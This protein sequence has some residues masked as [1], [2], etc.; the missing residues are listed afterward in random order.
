MRAHRTDG[1]SLT[2]AVVFG[3]FVGWWGLAQAIDLE[4]P[5][6]GW[7]VAGALIL[8]GLLGV[9]GALRAGR[10]DS[11][12]GPVTPSEPKTDGGDPD[13]TEILPPIEERP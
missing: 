9:L 4:L 6:V 2:F 10:T 5:T 7:F 3:V 11:R 1:V 13:S 8:I 12:P